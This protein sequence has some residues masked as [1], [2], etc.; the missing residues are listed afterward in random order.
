MRRLNQLQRGVPTSCH[1]Q[2]RFRGTEAKITCQSEKAKA[3]PTGFSL[4]KATEQKTL[5]KGFDGAFLLGQRVCEPN[6]IVL[7]IVG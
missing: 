5:S 6:A 4:R 7:R 3:Q 2:S 1:F